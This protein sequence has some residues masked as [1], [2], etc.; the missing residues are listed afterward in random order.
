LK[1]AANQ[2]EILIQ[3]CFADLQ[4]SNQPEIPDSEVFG[5]LSDIP[6]ARRISPLKMI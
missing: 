6:V 1:G 4:K 2:V 3:F 5:P